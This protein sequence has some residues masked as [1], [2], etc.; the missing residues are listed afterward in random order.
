MLG[1]TFG[2]LGGQYDP[3]VEVGQRLFELEHGNPAGLSNAAIQALSGPCGPVERLGDLVV[4]VLELVQ[5][6]GELDRPTTDL[7][8]RSRAPTRARQILPA[9]LVIPDGV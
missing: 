4:V 3:I 9:G 5:C 2:A 6:S 7:S 8:P 1:C